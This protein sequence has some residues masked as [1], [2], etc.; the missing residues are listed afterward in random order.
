MTGVVDA[1]MARLTRIWS[2][3][4]IGMKVLIFDRLELSWSE[5]TLENPFNHTYAERLFAGVKLRGFPIPGRM[6]AGPRRRHRGL[7]REDCGSRVSAAF[8]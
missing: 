2:D 1:L 3:L 8:T 4:E 5:F 6:E 7:S